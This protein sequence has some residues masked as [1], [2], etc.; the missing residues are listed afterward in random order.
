[1]LTQSEIN[2]IID[3]VQVTWQQVHP[4]T[5][6]ALYMLRARY[7]NIADSAP[8]R[9]FY[10]A[11]NLEDEYAMRVRSDFLIGDLHQPL[12]YSSTEIIPAGRLQ[13]MYQNTSIFVLKPEQGWHETLLAFDKT[14]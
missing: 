9:V 3:V 2:A 7:L 10:V 14:V 5:L 6:R 8:I 4:F 1:V 12:R 13:L 11:P